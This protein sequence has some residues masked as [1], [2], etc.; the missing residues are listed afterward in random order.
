MLEFGKGFVVQ[1][2]RGTTPFGGK[3]IVDRVIN[4]F[5]S[6][7]HTLAAGLDGARADR[8]ADAREVD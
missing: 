2:D 1:Y 3:S 6:N 8:A 7:F 5:R 4:L